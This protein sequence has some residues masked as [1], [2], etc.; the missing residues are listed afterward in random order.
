MLAVEGSE[1]SKKMLA[2]Q[3]E[4]TEKVLSPIS[5][6]LTRHGIDAKSIAKVGH[7]GK[8]ISKTTESSTPKLSKPVGS[9]L[10]DR[11]GLTENLLGAAS[12]LLKHHQSLEI[13]ADLQLI[14]HAHAAVQ[15]HGAVAHGTGV[16]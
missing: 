12:R 11:N 3:R 9:P 5:I 7:A 8:I 2:Y 16:T 6:F 13:G 1:F 4:E 15:L 14:C 10:T